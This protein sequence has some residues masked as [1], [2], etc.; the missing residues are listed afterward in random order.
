M[1]AGKRPRVV[2]FGAIGGDCAQIRG[3]GTRTFNISYSTAFKHKKKWREQLFTQHKMHEMLYFRWCLRTDKYGSLEHLLCMFIKC[4]RKTH[5]QTRSSVKQK[6]K[7]QHAHTQSAPPWKRSR[8]GAL[9]MIYAM[10]LFMAVCALCSVN[11][12]AYTDQCVQNNKYTNNH[13]KKNWRNWICNHYY[14][15]RLAYVM[16]HL[17]V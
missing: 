9:A 13:K 15:V 5:V 14:F 3:A 1:Q 8:F 16:C 12:K 17:H 4:T 11:C 7:K 6:K 10:S 2:F